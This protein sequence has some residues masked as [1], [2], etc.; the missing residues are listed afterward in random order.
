MSE[1]RGSVDADEIRN[2]EAMADD[3]WNPSGR[4]APLHRLNPTRLEWLK[5]EICRRFDRDFASTGALE[6]LRILDIGCGGGLL[7]L[8]LARLGA[9]MVG[10]DAGA[11]N[12]AAARAQA[13][14]LGLVVDWRADT[15]EALAEA[16][17]S[18]DVVVAMEIVEHVADLPLFMRAV[19]KCV[20]PGGL[21]ALA[22]LNRTAKSFA[23][24]VVGAEWIL[25][26]LPPGTHD[27]S[28]FVTPKELARV[29]EATGLEV[30]DACGMVYAPLAGTWR[31]AAGD[32][33]V[34]YLM[35]AE[36]PAR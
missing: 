5:R 13:E 15:A 24:A 25:R 31:L 32:L 11:A 19:A 35:L 33:D 12:V 18:F 30:L 29:V 10:V 36:R 16:G 22:T 14:R 27:W 21:L 2:F 3:W 4:M 28:R 23:L 7:T 8:P 9:D 1:R 20:R 26:W 34:N 6:G 17:E